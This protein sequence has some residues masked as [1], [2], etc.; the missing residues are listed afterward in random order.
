MVRTR[1]AELFD[2]QVATFIAATEFQ[3]LEAGRA[4]REQYDAFIED[5]ARAHLKS[6]QLLAFLYSIAPPASTG[7]VL[8]NLLEELGM[9]DETG[10]AHPALLRELVVGAGL[11]SRLPEIEARA[12]DDLRRVVA[13]PI[14][15]G[16]LRDVGLAALTEIVA[17][18][19]MLSRVSRRIATALERHRGLAPATLRWFTHH[20]EVD[21]AHAEQG[22]DG[23]DAYVRYYGLP[24]DEALT[25]VE[26]TLR[27]NVFARRYFR[28]AVG[29]AR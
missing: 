22:L 8:H 14:L 15:Y 7:A 24:V 2:S 9:E 27:E 20:S 6:P 13:D 5:V 19:Y 11:A 12:E 1:I 17:F 3:D 28:P 4:A 23:L 25:I 21:R 26:M 29:S 10:T 18:E 16:S